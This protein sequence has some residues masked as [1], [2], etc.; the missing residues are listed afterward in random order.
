MSIT[1]EA[2]TVVLADGKKASIRRGKGRDLLQAA[3]MAGGAQ[4]TIRLAF[5]IIAVLT[6]IDGLP[7]T[8]ED[9]ED[10]GMGDVQ[11]LMAATMGNDSS[12][13]SSTL[14]SSGSTEDSPTAS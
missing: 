8:L 10:M 12:S 4:D 7:I 1:T 3:R 9:V 11:T 2:K 6:L 13:A 14:S 5:G